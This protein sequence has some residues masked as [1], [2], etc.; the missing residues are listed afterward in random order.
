[1]DLVGG[2][3]TENLRYLN[4]VWLP[5]RDAV[6]NAIKKRF[7][8][9]FLIVRQLFFEQVDQSG[10]II[11]F[12]SGGLPW[13]EHLFSLESHTEPTILYC[14]YEDEAKQSWRIQCVPEKDASFTSR[15]VFYCKYF[16]VL[17]IFLRLFADIHCHN[18]GAACEMQNW[19]KCAVLKVQVSVTQR[20]S[21]VVRKHMKQHWQWHARHV[22]DIKMQR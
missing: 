16:Y 22:K 21:L 15:F 6:A 2:E 18:N 4:N 1:M 17:N 14:L 11:K 12:E 5:A 3:F 20:V 9:C 8:V 19:Q 10:R 7:E 13:K